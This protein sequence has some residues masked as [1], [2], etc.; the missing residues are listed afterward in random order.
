RE[1]DFEEFRD[2]NDDG[3]NQNE[4]TVSSI[5]KDMLDDFNSRLVNF[6]QRHNNELCHS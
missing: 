3:M 4:Q 6:C 1:E 2:G 5:S